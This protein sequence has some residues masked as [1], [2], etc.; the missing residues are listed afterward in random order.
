VE[1]VVLYLSGQ[2]W[3]I[4]APFSGQYKPPPDARGVGR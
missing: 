1:A 4:L 3:R 2:R